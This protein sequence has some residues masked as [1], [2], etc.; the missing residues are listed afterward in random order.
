MRIQTLLKPDGYF[1]MTCFNMKEGAPITDE[2]VYLDRSMHG[3]DGLYALK[4]RNDLTH[5]LRF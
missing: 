4:I 3:G 1:L 5:Y 2:Q